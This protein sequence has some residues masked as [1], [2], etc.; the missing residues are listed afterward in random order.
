VVALA[1]DMTPGAWITGGL[2]A[3]GLYVCAAGLFR[4]PDHP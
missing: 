1:R 2:C 4:R 3:I